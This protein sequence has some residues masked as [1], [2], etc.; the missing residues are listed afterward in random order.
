MEPRRTACRR[1]RR[2]LA[3]RASGVY[4]TISLRRRNL[5]QRGRT[6]ASLIRAKL[7]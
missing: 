4:M 7:S 6:Q 2:A 1:R 5:M 3:L